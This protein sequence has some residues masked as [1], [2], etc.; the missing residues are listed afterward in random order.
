MTRRWLVWAAV[1]C[2]VTGAAETSEPTATGSPAQILEKSIAYHDP[3]G[4]WGQARVHLEV[5][6]TYSDEFAKRAGSKEARLA[7]M[8]A[9]GQEEF[10]Y[11]KET[12]ADKLQIS[13][14]RGVGTLQLNGSTNVS[15]DDKQ[16]LR[17]RAAT[18]YRDYCEYLYGMPMKLRDPGTILGPRVKRTRFDD[19]DALQLRVTYEPEIGEDIWYFYFDPE[20][21]ALIGYQFYHDESKNDGEYITF[22]GEIADDASGL[23]LPKARAWYYNADDGHLATDDIVSLSTS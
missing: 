20:S 23:R 7:I 22:E 15:E 8:M 5:H 17:I 6:T 2:L 4:V 1:T 21:F 13:V 12:S 11:A 19:R 10:S 14:Q 3:N 16:R 18:M 9:P